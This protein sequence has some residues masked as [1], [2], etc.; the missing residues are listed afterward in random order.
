MK[1]SLKL[2]I[3]LFIFLV[4]GSFFWK[5]LKSNPHLI[6]SPLIN[7]STPNFAI[8]NL[9]N[10]S[11]EI[12]Q[13]TFKGK[14][15][16]LNVFATWCLACLDEQSVL[17]DISSTSQVNLI[18]LDYKDHRKKALNWLEEYGNPY[19]EILFDK[20]G[21]L[22]IEFGVYGTPES[23]IIDKKGVIRYKHVGPISQDLWKIELLP[24]I[25]RLENE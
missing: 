23:F 14:V 6:Q 11:C 13:E 8:Q 1:N 20:N 22:A 17:M 15:T 9:G 2:V 25:K 16:L 7:Q 4:L 3:P 21:T 12:S 24:L 5:G 10:P 19:Q 18:G